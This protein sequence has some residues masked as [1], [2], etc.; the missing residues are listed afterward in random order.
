MKDKQLVDSSKDTEIIVFNNK[1]CE[2]V[3]YKI[4]EKLF[5][6]ISNIILYN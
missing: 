6:T 2:V 3:R 4:Y 5:S 1:K